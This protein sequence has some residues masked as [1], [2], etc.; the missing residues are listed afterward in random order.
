MTTHVQS[1]LGLS[2]SC[3][4]ESS[5]NDD[6]STNSILALTQAGVRAIPHNFQANCIYHPVIKLPPGLWMW[7]GLWEGL[8]FSSSPNR[9]LCE[10]R[11]KTQGSP[12]PFSFHCSIH[13]VGDLT[14]A[15]AAS[16]AHIIAG[17]SPGANISLLICSYKVSIFHQNTLSALAALDVC[18]CNH[19]DAVCLYLI[20]TFFI[21]LKYD[22]DIL[23]W[24]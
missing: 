23:F 10:P 24:I 22:K 6:E 13:C 18:L 5:W 19:S 12:S 17:T 2:C 3:N 21:C 16:T 9:R 15:A 11:L 4:P 7:A 20:K 1:S 8:H 14:A